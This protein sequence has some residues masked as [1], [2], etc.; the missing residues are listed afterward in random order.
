MWSK[1]GIQPNE[2]KTARLILMCVPFA[3]AWDKLKYIHSP[4]SVLL[5]LYL[6]Y[7]EVVFRIRISC[8]KWAKFVHEG[9][10]RRSNLQWLALLIIVITLTMPLRVVCWA[11]CVMPFSCTFSIYVMLRCRCPSAFCQFAFYASTLS[12]IN[13]FDDLWNRLLI[14]FTERLDICPFRYDNS[15]H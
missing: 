6:Q 5:C 13:I 4:E 14:E 8:L 1:R 7:M 11:K 9:S 15:L 12:Y 2:Q 10:G 3:R